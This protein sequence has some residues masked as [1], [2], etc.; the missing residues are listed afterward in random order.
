MLIKVFIFISLTGLV[1]GLQAIPIM[2]RQNTKEWE[3]ELSLKQHL[4]GLGQK[5]DTSQ[6]RGYGYGHFPGDSAV[7]Y[8]NPADGQIPAHVRFQQMPVNSRYAGNRGVNYHTPN[9]VQEEDS[10]LSSDKQPAH[11]RF[12]QEWPVNSRYAGNSGVNYHPPN[13]VQ[14]EDSS[15]SSDKQPAA[16]VRFQQMPINSRYAGN[17]GVNYHTPNVVQEDDSSL[18]SDKQPAHVRLR[19][20]QE[21]PG[22][23]R[24]AGNSG[25]NYHTPNVVV[26]STIASVTAVDRHLLKTNMSSWLLVTAQRT[27]FLLDTIRGMIVDSTIA[28]VTAIDR[29][30]LLKTNM[31]WLLVTAQRTIFLLDNIRGMVV[32]S[33]IASVTAISRPFLL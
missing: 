32:D 13:S 7:N 16:H 5:L 18:S 19:L 21:W 6:F 26:D 17:S 23:S 1:P 14:K 29:P 10:S 3:T 12:Q 27:I 15:L 28:S 24:Y 4:H 20:Q 8:Y 31:S 22:N 2:S 30:F 25:V 11:V 33:T 9:V